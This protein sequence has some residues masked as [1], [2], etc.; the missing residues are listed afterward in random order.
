MLEQGENP[1]VV[2]EVL[3]HS[4]ITYTMDT[5]SHV[6]L[7][8]QKEAGPVRQEVRRVLKAVTELLI[9]VKVR[10]NDRPS[11]P[12]K[13]IRLKNK[14]RVPALL[15]GARSAGLEPATFSVRSP[16]L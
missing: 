9:A 2:Q 11:G 1:K 13:R 3:G 16:I 14:T 12:V 15:K 8:I 5:Y 6:S 7:N 10:S 4:R